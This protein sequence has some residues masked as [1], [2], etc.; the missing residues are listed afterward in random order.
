MS[1]INNKLLK[2]AN[3]ESEENELKTF[4]KNYDEELIYE[5][6]TDGKFV[7]CKLFKYI[8]HFL[9]QFHCMATLK[10]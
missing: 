10:P 7:I 8:I 9:L 4:F 5:K 6:S 3:G 1:L 2:M